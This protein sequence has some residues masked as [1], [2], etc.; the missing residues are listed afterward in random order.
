MNEF[1]RHPL[2]WLREAL[3]R[4]WFEIMVIAGAKVALITLVLVALR[5]I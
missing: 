3:R 1:L 5:L 2:F 4:H